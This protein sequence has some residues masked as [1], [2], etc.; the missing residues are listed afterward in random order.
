MNAK[1]VVAYE[2]LYGNGEVRLHITD[3]EKELKM[4]KGSEDCGLIHPN[5][6]G[7]QIDIDGKRI[8]INF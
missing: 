4:A 5:L 1:T 2:T 3:Q 6:T 7:V 8:K